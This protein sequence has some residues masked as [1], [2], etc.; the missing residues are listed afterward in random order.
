MWLD[1]ETK[2]RVKFVRP[3]LLVAV[4]TSVAQYRALYS[5]AR[6]LADY[7]LESLEFEE[8]A[9]V[10]SSA[11][12]PEVIVKDDGTAVLPT[13]RLHALR[14]KR[15]LLLF[16]GDSSPSD[17]QRQFAKVLLDY[18][19]KIGVKEVYSVGARWSETPV[20]AF[21]DPHVNGFAT[22]KEGVK[23]LKEHGVEIIGPEP[24]PFFASMIVGMAK[25]YGMRGYKISVDHG[26]PVP[27]TRSVIKMLEVLSA[28]I[29]FKIDTDKLR[30][31]VKTPPEERSP[32]AGRIYQ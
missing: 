23:R 9:A 10:R 15:D 20:P 28:M 1:L 3:A 30:A 16:A 17:D 8:V 24:A 7:L 14:G 22:D 2:S 21:E 19:R 26:E 25:D 27:H 11:F 32:G 31:H 12:A 29:G 5:Q 13:C 18:A 6:E 4:S